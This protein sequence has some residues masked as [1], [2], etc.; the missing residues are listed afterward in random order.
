MKK[1]IIVGASSGIG[2]ELAILYANKKWLVGVTGRRRE[3]LHELRDQYPEQIIPLSFD[4]TSDDVEYHL[5]LLISKLGG[6]DLLIL[7]SGSGALN[8]SLD[9]KVEQ[10]T[11]ELNV[12]AWTQIAD[13][14]F[15]YFREQEH[16]HFAAITSIASIRGE[17]RAPAYNASK[18]FQANYL[19]GLRKLAVFLKL[20]ITVT[21]IQ[22]GFVKTKM[23]KGKGRFWEAPPEKAARQIL[24]AIERKKNKV[25]I[26]KRWWLVALVLKM[27]PGWVYNRI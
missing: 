3:L 10:E 15:S 25:Y 23:A 22:P 19:E 18:S 1:V 20:K 17:G 16:G 8:T 24:Y 4:N 26:T 7:S 9:W 27:M 11:I 21:D 6:L 12:M 14:I 5:Q 2:R 13:F